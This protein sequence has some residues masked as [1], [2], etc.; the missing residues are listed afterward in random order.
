MSNVLP[1]VE[2]D[3]KKVPTRVGYRVDDDGSKV[4]VAKKTG[5]DL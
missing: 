1:V 5:E 4:R 3:G 2:V